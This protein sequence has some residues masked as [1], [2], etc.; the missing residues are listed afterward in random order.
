M[1]KSGLWLDKGSD[2]KDWKW[3]HEREEKDKEQASLRKAMQL[4]YTEMMEEDAKKRREKIH[5][6]GP[7]KFFRKDGTF[8][9]EE[10]E[11]GDMQ[12]L[13]DA[14]VAVNTKYSVEPN[15]W[16]CIYAPNKY[17]YDEVGGEGFR[18]GDCEI[19]QNKGKIAPIFT[20]NTG[21]R[22]K[23]YGIPAWYRTFDKCRKK[24]VAGSIIRG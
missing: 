19:G 6:K 22:T 8:W 17:L 23:C 9:G 11:K 1:K 20:D 21:D 5:G 16:D 10:M 3:K 18:R 7:R 14:S 2:G 13:M 15:L 24:K 12:K 4:S